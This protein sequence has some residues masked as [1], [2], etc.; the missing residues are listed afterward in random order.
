VDT[1]ICSPCTADGDGFAAEA[2]DGGLDRLLD[3]RVIILTL[4]AGIAGP[5]IFDVEADSAAS[6]DHRAWCYRRSTQE[7]W[8]RERLA[9]GLLQA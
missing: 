1:G 3:R 6:A 7:V 2:V 4:P 8:G 9:A 5:V